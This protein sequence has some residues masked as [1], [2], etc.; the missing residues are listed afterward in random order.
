VYYRSDGLAVGSVEHRWQLVKIIRPQRPCSSA[1]SAPGAEV[2][3]ALRS[4][5][6]G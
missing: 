4:G 3:I 5:H 1:I 6:P 2:C